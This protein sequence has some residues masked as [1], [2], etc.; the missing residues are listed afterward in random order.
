MHVYD[1]QKNTLFATERVDRRQETEYSYNGINDNKRT[2]SKCSQIARPVF[3][4][5]GRTAFKELSLFSTNTPCRMHVTN[6]WW[7]QPITVNNYSNHQQKLILLLFQ[8]FY[9]DI[10]LVD[11]MT[12]YQNVSQSSFT[13]KQTEQYKHFN[14]CR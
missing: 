4:W 13:H 7:F 14:T 1:D 5:L 2:I 10:L 8:W 11:C 3:W 12:L 9:C 6:I